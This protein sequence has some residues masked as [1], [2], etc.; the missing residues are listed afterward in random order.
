[1]ANPHSYFR[2][3]IMGEILSRL[4]IDV[5]EIPMTGYG[6]VKQTL[7]PLL[8]GPANFFILRVQFHLV[9]GCKPNF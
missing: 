1:M 9:Q 3:C 7:V 2:F 5:E 6:L 4:F 8:L